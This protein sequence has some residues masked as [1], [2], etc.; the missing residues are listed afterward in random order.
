MP[1][2]SPVHERSVRLP[3]PADTVFAW[4]TRPGA[5][6]R[7]TPP[8]EH[9][10]VLERSGGIEDGGQVTVKIGSPFG[11]RWVARHRDYDPGH[12][13]TDEQIRGP[14]SRWVHEHR[15]DPTAPTP[16]S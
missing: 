8:W 1:S 11:F 5:L 6:E 2:G 4:H 13:F 16:A 10:Q 15:V 14:F 3:F 7:L 12:Q 9:I